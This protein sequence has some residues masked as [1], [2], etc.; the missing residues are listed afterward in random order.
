MTV[1][2]TANARAMG[3]RQADQVGPL[4]FLLDSSAAQQTS[5]PGWYMPAGTSNK[6]GLLRPG[7][8][9]ANTGSE[10]RPM[11]TAYHPRIHA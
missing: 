9:S 10:T 2:A 7:Q 5:G 6:A 3:S 1:R 8:V 11:N 4:A